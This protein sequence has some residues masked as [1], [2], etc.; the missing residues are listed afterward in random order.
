[1][2]CF[3]FPSRLGAA[4]LVGGWFLVVGGGLGDLST[5]FSWGLVGSV[6]SILVV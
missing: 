6:V 1:M 4:G 5:G 2:A 3:S